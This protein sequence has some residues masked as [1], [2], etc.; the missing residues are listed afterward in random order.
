MVLVAPAALV[1]QAALVAL[2][3]LVA[4]ADSE[5]CRTARIPARCT[6]TGA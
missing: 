6:A 3:V 2:V 1:V 4:P 5:L